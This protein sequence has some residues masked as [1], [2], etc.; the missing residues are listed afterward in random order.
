MMLYVDG[1][2]TL[3]TATKDA[4]R[5][6]LA[7]RLKES[8]KG[9]RVDK[10]FVASLA[11]IPPALQAKLDTAERIA[12]LMTTAQQISGNPR[13][14]KR[15]LNALAIRTTIAKSQGVSVNEAAL[16]KLLLFER[17]AKPGQ[18][19]K[20]AQAVNS[21]TDGKPAFLGP[22][23][24]AIDAGE[25]LQIEPDWDDEFIRDW[26]G[27]PPALADSDLRGELY[28]A[29]EHAPLITAADK[30]SSDASALLAAILEYP[31]QAHAVTTQLTALPRVEL[32]SILDRVLD[33]AQ[34]EQSWGVP[35]ILE[36]C[37][38]LADVESGFGSRVAGFLIERPAS[39]IEPSIVPKIQGHTWAQVVLDHWK[40]SS[41]VSG[42]VKAAIARAGAK[43]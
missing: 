4:I 32:S 14:V 15:F 2:P 12:P 23:E 29:R 20:L 36:V 27:L 5:L 43:T 41:E 1:D 17:L 16:A 35:G 22:W 13:L 21:A 19:D 28:V 40:D 31:E 24:R 26:L 42:P 11:E 18:Y 6:G 7:G 8:W 33:R 37:I 25:S 39:Q 30:L 10:S 34:R 9:Q 3:S 38:I